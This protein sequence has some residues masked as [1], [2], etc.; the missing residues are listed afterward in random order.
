M[1]PFFLVFL[2]AA[3]TLTAEAPPSRPVA[4]TAS[5]VPLLGLVDL[6]GR[7]GLNPSFT[8][9]LTGWNAFLT[10]RGAFARGAFL[11]GQLTVLRTDVLELRAGLRAF[12][13]QEA[14]DGKPLGGLGGRVE[15]RLALSPTLSMRPDF[16]LTWLGPLVSARFA[17]ELAVTLGEWRLGGRAGVQ[18]WVRDADT[19]VA[20]ALALS[21]GL[22]HEVGAVTLDV[23][24]AL[25][26]T[27][28]SS[29]LLEHPVLATP[30]PELGFDASLHAAL[31]F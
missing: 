5:A 1:S 21:V 11:G 29:F 22:R 23:G 10:D 24:A 25:G 18:V 9:E 31:T 2:A 26:V 6:S 14:S 20:P 7:V 27:R 8:L 28:D 4:I 3:P 15:T 19:Q 17:N 12:A 30:R 13:A 16:D